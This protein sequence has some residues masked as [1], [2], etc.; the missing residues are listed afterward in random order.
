MNEI[1]PPVNATAVVVMP[2]GSD[3]TKLIVVQDLQDE[4]MKAFLRAQIV[5]DL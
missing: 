2:L 3:Q 1:S 5:Q 4:E